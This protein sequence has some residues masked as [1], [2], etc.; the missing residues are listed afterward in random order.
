MEAGSRA[1]GRLSEQGQEAITA[2]HHLTAAT[3]EGSGP[4]MRCRR[5]KWAGKRRMREAMNQIPVDTGRSSAAPRPAGQETVHTCPL[6]RASRHRA[7][8]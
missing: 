5:S 8:P 2:I 7:R 3:A 1:Q 6:Q 4:Q